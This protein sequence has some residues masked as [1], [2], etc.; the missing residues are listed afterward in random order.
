VG[1]VAK[2]LHR[3]VEVSIGQTPAAAL[4]IAGTPYS[5]FKYSSHS[6]RS[7]EP[8]N[9]LWRNATVVFSLLDHRRN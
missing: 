8:S 9:Q 2:D 6:L 3:F 4:D 5:D 1:F 7:L